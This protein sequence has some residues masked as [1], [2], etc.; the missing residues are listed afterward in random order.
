[1]DQEFWRQRWQSRETGFHEPGGNALLAKWFH[2]LDL[3]A[4]QRVFV[5]LCGKTRDIAWL[6]SKDMHVTGC[7]LSEIAVQELFDELNISPD[8]SENGNYKTCSGPAIEIFTGDLFRLSGDIIGKVDAVYDRAAL[9]A[10]PGEMRRLY[11][12]KIMQITGHA[13]QLVIS[14]EYDQVEMEGPPFS[15]DAAEI[16]ALYSA[17]Y[18]INALDSIELS[19]G[20]KGICTARE[21]VW[22]LS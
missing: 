19:G 6:L 10:L 11:S 15:V 14:F 12:E 7:E 4:G 20:L 9:V 17:H 18:E 5:P 8:I 1:M 3:V 13:P 2:R 21:Q 16:A 22:Y